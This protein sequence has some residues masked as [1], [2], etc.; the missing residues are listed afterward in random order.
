MEAERLGESTCTP[1]YDGKCR[2]QNRQGH[3]GS[4]GGLCRSVWARGERFCLR[5]I[6][7][8]SRTQNADVEVEIGS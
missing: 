6:A 7:S 5:A 2:D 8:G 4:A 1:R 3:E